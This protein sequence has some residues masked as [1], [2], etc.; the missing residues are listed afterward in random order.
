MPG[1]AT[2]IGQ[3]PKLALQKTMLSECNMGFQGWKDST[4]PEPRFA[5]AAMLVRI[6]DASTEVKLNRL[7]G[8]LRPEMN[9]GG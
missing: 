4:M 7:L 1:T 9:L 2:F 3:A 6:S 8:W 5:T